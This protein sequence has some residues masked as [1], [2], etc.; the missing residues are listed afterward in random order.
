MRKRSNS[1]KATK[2]ARTEI[3]NTNAGIKQ[4]LLNP[5]RGLFPTGLLGTFSLVVLPDKLSCGRVYL[6][7]LNKKYLSLSLEGL[8]FR[9]NHYVK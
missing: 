1:E 4:D 7:E 3:Q 6:I 5:S 9:P 2:R 8:L